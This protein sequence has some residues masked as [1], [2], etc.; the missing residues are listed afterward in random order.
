MALQ[1]TGVYRPGGTLSPA[2]V[3]EG[4]EDCVVC[5]SGMAACTMVYLT[6][7]LYL[8]PERRTTFGVEQNTVRLSVGIEPSEQIIAD[9]RQALA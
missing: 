1:K 8:P 7:M 3:L 6:T 5:T 2:S 9:L 4:A